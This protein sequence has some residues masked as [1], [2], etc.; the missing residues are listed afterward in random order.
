MRTFTFLRLALTGTLL[1]IA[2]VASGCGTTT[3][4]SGGGTTDTATTDDTAA[5]SDA[6]T[7]GDTTTT[8]DT[9]GTDAT[10]GV[11]FTTI[12]PQIQATCATTGCHTTAD[13]KF[14]GKLDLSTQDLAY[15]GLVTAAKAD[16]IC[17]PTVLVKAGDHAASS[18]WI[19]MSPD[20]TVATAGPCGDPVE[21]MPYN[22]PTAAWSAADVAKVAAWID[23]GAAK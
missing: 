15:A 19:R 23:A 14:A 11:S 9:T 21:K 3:S 1:T 8:G 17:T 22:K 12:Y 7:G 18:L 4:S 13:N 2:L 16:A 20:T 6:A 10:A 5:G